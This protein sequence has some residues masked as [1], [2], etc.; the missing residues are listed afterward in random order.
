[1]AKMND[2]AELFLVEH[3][4]TRIDVSD[5][6]PLQAALLDASARFTARGAPVSY[7]GSTFLPGPG[8]LLSLFRASDAEAVRRVSASSQA[9]L[10]SLEAAIDLPAPTIS[11]R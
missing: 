6:A 8:R 5:L 4:L 3:R 1:M 2:N 9:P 10:L 11:V 7:L